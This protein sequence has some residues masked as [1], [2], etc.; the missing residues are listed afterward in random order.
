MLRQTPRRKAPRNFTLTPKMVGIRPP[1][2]RV[3]PALSWGSAVAM[4]MF[5]CTL[6]YNLI[7]SG[8]FGA[9]APK[10]SDISGIAQAPAAATAAPATMAPATAAPAAPLAPATSPS[11]PNQYLAPLG[12]P[13]PAQATPN[14]GHRTKG[15]PTFESTPTGVPCTL[16]CGGGPADTPTNDIRS[17]AV[18]PPTAEAA[19]GA[20]PAG[21]SE[22]QA[23]PQKPLPWAYIWLGL[24]ALL[25]GSSFLVRWLSRRAF[26]RKTKK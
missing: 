4:V 2:P 16:G 23:Q 19:T 8:A 14:P 11:A 9:A 25:I 10:A 6:G 13:T 21:T 5:V 22:T 18:A 3:V 1:V 7:S 24:A 26:A 17:M 12:T 20:N 15:T